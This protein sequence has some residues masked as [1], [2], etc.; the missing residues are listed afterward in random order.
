MVTSVPIH[1][2]S[3]LFSLQ[4]PLEALYLMKAIIGE[5]VKSIKDFWSLVSGFG[6]NCIWSSFPWRDGHDGANHVVVHCCYNCEDVNLALSLT[7]CEDIRWFIYLLFW[8]FFDLIKRPQQQ[9][10]SLKLVLL[11]W[12]CYVPKTLNHVLRLPTYSRS[13]RGAL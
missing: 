4:Y 6:D 1:H 7:K 9:T 11:R 2:L 12:C 5:V 10:Q 13:W 8:L 3:P